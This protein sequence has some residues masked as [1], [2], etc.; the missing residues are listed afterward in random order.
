MLHG[1][2]ARWRTS[3]GVDLRVDVL[4]VVPTVLCEVTSCWA[5]SLLESPLC[6]QPEDLD[7]AV[8]QARRPVAT[9]RDAVTG[10]AEN[11]LDCA[12]VQ[13]TGVYVFLQCECRLVGCMR[14]PVWTRLAHRV[15]GGRRRE[16]P[17][18]SACRY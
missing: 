12:R 13:A 11:R 2:Q 6:Q 9:T 16:E 1:E 3:R 7:L 8:G 5:M 10:G 15:I 4:D 17:G 14:R 18:L